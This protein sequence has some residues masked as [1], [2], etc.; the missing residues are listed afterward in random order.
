MKVRWAERIVRMHKLETRTIFMSWD[1]NEPVL[2]TDIE[3]YG[4]DWIHL[5]R[6]RGRRQAFCKRCD[7]PLGSMATGNFVDWMSSA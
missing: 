2:G 1:L 3:M 6:D 4:V 7:E 5:A